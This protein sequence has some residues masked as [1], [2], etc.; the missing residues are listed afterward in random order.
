MNTTEY[1]KICEKPDLPS[2]NTPKDTISPGGESLYQYFKVVA[3]LCAVKMPPDLLPVLVSSSRMD[4]NS[5]F[6]QSLKGDKETIL[7]W[8]KE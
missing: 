7:L 8:R 6:T 1:Y 5:L 4:T 3:T 2:L